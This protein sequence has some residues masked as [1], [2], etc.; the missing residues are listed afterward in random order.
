MEK[1]NWTLV[2]SIVS[3]V[4]M[5]IS[6]VA[7]AAVYKDR[8]DSI[9]NYITPEWIENHGRMK[10]RVRELEHEVDNL[11]NLLREEYIIHKGSKD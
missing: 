4:V 8:I 6:L 11:Q 3:P 10:E 7:T 5:A 1:V 2:L 9:T